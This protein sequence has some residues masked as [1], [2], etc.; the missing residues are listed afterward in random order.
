MA[1][2]VF[3]S[4]F[5]PAG[6]ATDPA[7]D[8][9]AWLSELDKSTPAGDG[10]HVENLR[11]DLGP[12]HLDIDTG[13]LVAVRGPSVRT[14]EYLFAGKARFVLATDDPVEAYQLELFTLRDRLDE[15]VTRAVLFIAS[16]TVTAALG[17]RPGATP[18]SGDQA[19]RA[20]DTL[21]AWKQSR[22]YKRSALRLGALTDALDEPQAE[23]FA[24]AWCESPRLGRFLLRVDPFDSPALSVEQ[25][26]PIRVGDHD[27]EGWRR[28][29]RRE[30]SEGRRLGDD[31]DDFGYWDVWYTSG[32]P[33]G[34]GHS[35]FE[36]EHYDLET[37]IDD[38]VVSIQGRAVMSLVARS[39]GARV[40]E[41]EIFSDLTVD[42]VAVDG[43]ERLPIVQN[44][45]TVLAVLP[46][47]VSAGAKLG[48]DVRYHGVL[49]ERDELK[50]NVKQT[51]SDWYPLVGSINRATYRAIFHSPATGTLL[52]S[53]A[54]V[55][56]TVNGDVRR[57]VRELT[58]PS[59]FFGFELGKFKVVERQF[60]HVAVTV[61][62]LSDQRTASE[63]E[64][65]ATVATIGDALTTY[66]ERFGPYP[67]DTLCVAT[68]RY[69]FAQGFLG[70]VTLADG[71]VQ[72]VEGSDAGALEKRRIIA[73]E[74]AHQWWGN[75]VGWKSDSDVW[76]GESLANYSAALY[77]R[78][79][80]ATTG[81]ALQSAYLDLV[82]NADVLDSTSIVDRPLEAL[83][84]IV[85]GPRLFSS[86][87]D[88]AYQAI[89]YQKGAMVLALLAEQLG[90][91]PFLA[92][93]KEIAQRAN[94]RPLDT[95]T[96][97]AA[98]AKMSGRSLDGFERQFVRGVGYPQ[99]YY[100]Y[101][102]DPVEGGFGIRGTVRQVAHGYRR[103]RLV[104]V[105]EKGFDVVPT[106]REYQPGESAQVEI[107]ALVALS[108]VNSATAAP[109]R[110]WQVVGGLDAA[111][112][113][114]LKTTLNAAGTQ[115]PI[116]L[117]VVDRPHSLRLDPRKLLPSRVVNASIES[118]RALVGQGKAHRSVG[119]TEAAR[120]AF[121]QALGLKLTAVPEGIT[122]DRK[123]D[124][125]WWNDR[126]DGHTHL[127]LA[128]MNLDE[129]RF[130]AAAK[131]LADRT[132]NILVGVDSDEGVRRTAL[133]ARM[134]LHDGDAA[135][136]YKLLDGVLAVDVVQ[137]ETDT[138]VDDLRRNKLQ[139]GV[140]GT[141][142]EYLIYAAAAHA[143]GHETVCR[144]AT[145]EA[146]RHG[147]DAEVLDALHDGR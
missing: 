44:E 28:W 105:G 5:D 126:I 42:S 43:G 9:R 20:A 104:R 15:P 36:P 141:A 70:F 94:H 61:G 116:A 74:V 125:A 118:K 109:V 87:S 46:A 38:D 52:G 127:E 84:P 111:Q 138:L 49:F 100:D 7:R 72:D 83:G 24:A 55:E 147:G 57:Q 130:D 13:T 81:G 3:G 98:L 75:L 18:L 66:E 47:S 107:S 86:L 37:R 32:L 102:I 120:A 145:A 16:D 68:T 73:H 146:K 143:S 33:R 128:E 76:L 23:H 19:K 135:T 21:A 11:I 93:L 17:A 8:P 136:A 89:V 12:A 112:L 2:A 121:A 71:L 88:D 106:F 90:E 133:R 140:R 69:G 4:G 77:R 96:V 31:P 110:G 114:G 117:K 40:V 10:W 27:K 78:K 58:K 132:V 14:Q 29:L 63:S 50:R 113:R 64:R 103:D 92:M 34:A 51:T 108:E 97:L 119:N 131:D 142:R 115:S 45:G 134:A 99:I 124:I 53:G 123:N 1:L 80:A 129:N 62:F 144:E 35:S 85:L 60:G 95:K 82:V 91:A 26:V 139:S 48:I 41:M 79:V 30:Q 22:E 54:K 6:A 122:E 65:E 137:K 67:L 101:A 39:V 59:A 25:F 56:D